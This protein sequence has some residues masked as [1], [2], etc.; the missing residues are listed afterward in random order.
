VIPLFDAADW[1]TYLTKNAVG[2]PSPQNPYADDSPGA[3]YAE[4]VALHL[5]P[6]H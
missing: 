4:V 2:W 6:V 5:R 1:G 3:S